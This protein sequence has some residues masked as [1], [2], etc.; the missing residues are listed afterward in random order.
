MMKGKI[1]IWNIVNSG[2]L[3]AIVVFLVV[4]N[5]EV[6]PI[7]Y[8]INQEVFAGFKG[9]EELNEKLEHTRQRHKQV[10]D[11]LYSQLGNEKDGEAIKAFSQKSRGFMEDE[12]ELSDRYTQQIWKQINTYVNDYGKEND[13]EMIFGANGSGSLM[14]ASDAVNVTEEVLEYLNRRYAGEE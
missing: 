3:V 5:G 14:Y 10:L 11:S 6:H 8:V 9:R 12:Q 7:A 2:M 4:K 13:Y 1:L